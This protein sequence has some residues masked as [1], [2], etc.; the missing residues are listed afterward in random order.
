[1]RESS[2]PLCGQFAWWLYMQGIPMMC[3]EC[4]EGTLWLGVPVCG[5]VCRHSRLCSQAFFP[6][7]HYCVVCIHR[8]VIPDT[9]LCYFYIL[10]LFL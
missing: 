3:R 6:Y 4:E 1:M 8:C 9:F 2:G 7:E 5:G 10:V